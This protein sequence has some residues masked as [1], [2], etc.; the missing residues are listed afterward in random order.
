MYPNPVRLSRRSFVIGAGAAALAASLP[1][2]IS[3]RAFAVEGALFTPGTYTGSAAGMYGTTVVDVTVD[4]TSI[5]SIEVVE[6]NDTA[7]V[8]EDAMA[9]LPDAIIDAQSL[10]VDNVTGATMSS[11]GIR[12]AVED[13]LAQAGADLDALNEPLPAVERQQH[14]EPFRRGQHALR[15]PVNA[16]AVQRAVAGAMRLF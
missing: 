10:A 5:L 12:G 16:A 14:V 4:E 7:L 2:A 13:A 6:I 8:A 9:E 3:T 15:R 1:L 11:L